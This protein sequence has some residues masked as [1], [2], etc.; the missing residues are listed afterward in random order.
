MQCEDEIAGCSSAIGAAFAG[1]LAVTTTS[2]PGICLKSEAMN[3]AVITELPLVI[4]DVQRGGPSTG[5]PTKSEQTDLLQVL[6]GR[7]G[8]SPMPVIAATSPTNCFDAAYT[9]AKIALEHM[10]PVVLLTDA[11]IANGSAAWRLPDLNEYPDIKPPYV[12][13]GMEG[14]WTPFQRN[15]ETGVRYWA[16]PG[17]K[18]FMHRIGGLEKSNETGAISTE[19]ENHHLM[20]LLR[21][22]KVAKIAECIPDVEVQGDPDAD[23]LVVGF[24]GTYGHLYAAVEEMVEEGKKVALAHF[25]FINPLPKNTAE[26]LLRYKK[27]VVAEQNMGQFANYL[28][29]KVPG[30]AVSQYNQVKGQPFVEEELI[31][32]FTKLL[33][34]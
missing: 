9:A 27:V 31:K 17:T 12:T 13:P 5:M 14:T 15:P 19:P 24:G 7:N 1:D 32:A 28:R 6:F 2:G 22:E 18:G 30:L 33:E 4:I 16:L 3:L 20:T 25:E 11:F 10:T 34:E 26:V 21:Q 23:L 8:E 29:M